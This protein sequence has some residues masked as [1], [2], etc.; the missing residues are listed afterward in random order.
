MNEKIKSRYT[1]VPILLLILLFT[2]SFSSCDLLFGLLGSNTGTGSNID[3]GIDTDGDSGADP[4]PEP[5]PYNGIGPGTFFW[6]HWVRMD[7]TNEEWY[8]ASNGIDVGTSSR[9]TVSDLSETGFVFSGQTIV[10]I[11]DNLLEVTPNGNDPEYFLFRRSGATA[12]AVM[13]INSVDSGVSES[14]SRGFGISGLGSIQVVMNNIENPGNNQ[15][16][17]TNSDGQLDLEDIIVG[18]EYEL[19]IPAQDGIDADVE[20]VVSPLYDGEDLGIVNLNAVL[21]NFKV[22]YSITNDPEYLLAG[23]SYTL[24]ISIRN[25]GTADMRSADYFITEP[26]GISLTGEWLDNILGTVRAKGDPK[27]LVFTLQID[28]FD[29]PEKIFEIPVSVV[30]VDGSARWD[31]KLSL[32]VYRE[33]VTVYVRS[34]EAEVQGVLIS[35]DSTSIPFKTENREGEITLPVR[36][37]PYILALSGADYVSETRY[38]VGVGAPPATD[39]SELISGSINEPN[40]NENQTTPLFEG[41]S[42]LGYLAAY[43]LDFYRIWCGENDLVMQFDPPPGIYNE[44]INVSC[45]S[46]VG[47]VI[48]YTTDGSPVDEFSPIYADPIPV[49]DNTVI[50]VGIIGASAIS[51]FSTTSAYQLQPNGLSFN[52]ES[53]GFSMESSY[54]NAVIYYTTN[55]TDPRTNGTRY[56]NGQIVGSLTDGTQVRAIE[57]IGNWLDSDDFYSSAPPVPAISVSSY[58][59]GSSIQLSAAGTTDGDDSLNTLFFEWDFDNDGNWDTTSSHQY[60]VAL[61]DT[62][63]GAHTVNLRVTDPQ[64]VSQIGTYSFDLL[65]SQTMST[66]VFSHTNGNY[67]G[68]QTVTI[69]PG[70]SGASVYYT[71]NGSIPTSNSSLY[72]GPISISSS[73]TIR[74][75]THK[76]YYN[77]SVDQSCE[78]IYLSPPS[79]L[80][81]TY[82]A[83]SSYFYQYPIYSV[84]FTWNSVDGATKYEIYNNRLGQNYDRYSTS[85]NDSAYWSSSDYTFTVW[86]VNKYGRSATSK[87]INYNVPR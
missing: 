76:P 43:D 20:L 62:S 70:T 22:S 47:G 11:T 75:I 73:T 86:S 8:M 66:P 51:D 37:K 29:D 63:I 31:D 9:A 82:S 5:E 52:S 15:N 53:S 57:R 87:S 3:S 84:T 46:S 83:T 78:L 14:V 25:I 74:A 41:E 27:N 54:S 30:A 56:Y 4:D 67:A 24:T 72:T 81:Y 26:E 10:K 19:T 61:P 45:I 35:P 58:A 48:H 38:S 6:G 79:Y 2:I 65:S 60:T 55:N 44:P 40:N 1:S 33:Y 21:Q 50:T 18:D 13:V 12:E 17:I 28:D 59:A 7:G 69:T 16:L 68:T 85:A 77:P 36:E 39:G 42:E 32:R 23:E 80:T 34:D 64:G 71:L 49:D